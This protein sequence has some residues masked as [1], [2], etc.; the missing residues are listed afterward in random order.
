MLDFKLLK[1]IYNHEKH[2]K[3]K[4]LIVYRR[5]KTLKSKLLICI[6]IAVII[7]TGCIQEEQIA[8]QNEIPQIN[9]NNAKI[10]PE[11]ENII[12]PEDTGTPL[13]EDEELDS[14]LFQG[15]W[16]SEVIEDR[17]DLI[18]F[19]DIEFDGESNPIVNFNYNTTS[20]YH[21]VW[22]AESREDSLYFTYNGDEW[23]T[24]CVIYL[25]SKDVLICEL[26]SL[27][28]YGAPFDGNIKFERLSED[29]EKEY[30]NVI[31]MPSDLSKIRLLREYDEYG[32]ERYD[33]TFEYKFDERENMLD[34]I[35]K[36]N[37][38]E[39]VTGK[40]DAE[41]AIALMKWLCGLYKHG[42]PPARPD[43]AT[44]QIIMEFADNNGGTINCRYLSLVLAQLIRAYNIPAY[45]ITCMPYEQPFDDCHVV[46]NFYSES[47]DRWVM[48]DPTYNLYLMDENDEMIGVEEF[49]D[50]I[51]AGGQLK[52]NGGAAY[53]G[54]E[55]SFEIRGYREY[56][57]KNFIR[58][59]R[60]TI[61]RYGSDDNDGWITLIPEKYMQNEAK[62]FSENHW[63]N[64]MTSRE[65]FWGR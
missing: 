26:S 60:G 7:F 29:E 41:T 2:Y 46:V 57:A 12:E 39:L 54:V 11:P 15:K 62:N 64:F 37:L 52:P 20:Y 32:A 40:S 9:D 10:E 44:P 34:I 36:H 19:L 28:F 43:N 55:G 1:R 21:P 16:R 14:L 51:I 3:H 45:H 6:F 18:I 53:D 61:M 17:W 25:E 65:D 38:D 56:M 33:V 63:E 23:K 30:D 13:P 27:N 49:R 42:N 59:Q 24:D 47:L 35:E 4:I 50:I 22:H 48:L 31:V 8:V 5:I 58:L